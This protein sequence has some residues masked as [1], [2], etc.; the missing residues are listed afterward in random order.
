[1]DYSLIIEVV[2]TVSDA[3][4]LGCLK[5]LAYYSC[6]GVELYSIHFQCSPTVWRAGSIKTDS[7]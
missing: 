1:M 3:N 5:E 7:K 2:Y 4:H 6:A